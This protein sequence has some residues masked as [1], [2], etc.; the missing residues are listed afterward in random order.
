MAGWRGSVAFVASSGSPSH[1]IVNSGCL[2]VTT[3]AIRYHHVLLNKNGC[4]AVSPLQNL[5]RMTSAIAGKDV[6]R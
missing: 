6:V 1:R 5:V 2:N 3:L 4:L